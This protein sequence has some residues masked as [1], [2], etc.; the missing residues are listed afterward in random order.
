MFCVLCVSTYMFM[1]HD[2]ILHLREVALLW[3][4]NEL[5][6]DSICFFTEE[7]VEKNMH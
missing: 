6:L 3:E 4:C 1:L 5:D 2:H 7:A